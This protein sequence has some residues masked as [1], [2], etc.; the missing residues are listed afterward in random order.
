MGSEMMKEKYDGDKPE[1][2]DVRVKKLLVMKTKDERIDQLFRWV[3]EGELTTEDFKSLFKIVGRQAEIEE[4]ARDLGALDKK[5]GAKRASPDA[6][7]EMNALRAIR[8]KLGNL[9]MKAEVAAGLKE[10]T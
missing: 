3:L 7:A 4:L 10:T 6:A 8:Q 9:T 2:K 5:Y 1:T